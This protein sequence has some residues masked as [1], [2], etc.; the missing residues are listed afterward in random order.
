[1][2]ITPKPPTKLPQKCTQKTG[3]QIHYDLDEFRERPT[4][5][6]DKYRKQDENAEPI[7]TTT[8]D[9][10]NGYRYEI[11]FKLR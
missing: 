11:N 4:E 1:M 9:Q 10:G 2:D 3:Q 8:P 5:I 7:D 6:P